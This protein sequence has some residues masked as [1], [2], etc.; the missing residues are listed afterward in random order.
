MNTMELT[1][2]ARSEN[3]AF[4]RIVISGFVLPLDPTL[5]EM[6]E[7]KTIVSEAVTNSIIHAYDSKTNGKIMMKAQITSEDII[8][9][10]ITDYGKGIEDIRKAKE[11]FWT[12]KPDEE[13]TGMG[14]T[15]IEAFSDEF[16][17]SSSIGSGTSIK[18]RKKISSKL[19]KSA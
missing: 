18:V 2:D 16:H 5:D 7:I 3:E 12:S 1:F 9:I 8:E 10:Q 15:I 4:A 17:I 6:N 11:I 13:R 19:M 14:L